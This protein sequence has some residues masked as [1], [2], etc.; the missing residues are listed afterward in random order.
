MK[1]KDVKEGLPDL[2]TL[3]QY[4]PDLFLREEPIDREEFEQVIEKAST[5]LRQILQEPKMDA[6]VFIFLYSYLGNAYRI[7]GRAAKGVQYLE[8]A[9][10][11]ARYDEDEQAELRTMIR[12]GEAYKYAGDHEAALECFEQA[13]TMSRS[14]QLLE[15][16]DYALQHMGKCLMELGEYEEALAKL[17]E[18]LQ[19]RKEKEIEELILSTETAI[20]M[21]HILRQTTNEKVQ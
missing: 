17:E 20:V 13:L 16:K 19:I 10:E 5:F 11:M 8:R 14:Q 3:V 6:E 1:L 12:L 18:A 2:R 9:L 4:K 7:S 15:F 21:V